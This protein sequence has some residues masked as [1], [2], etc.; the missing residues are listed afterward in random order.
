MNLK[1]LFI[2]TVALMCVSTLLFGTVGCSSNEAKVFKSIT[3]T[4]EQVN[5]ICPMKID[6]QTTLKST[7]AI[8]PRTL[9]YNMII[10][11]P[12]NIE[13]ETISAALK[14]AVMQQIKSNAGVKVLR[15]MDVTFYYSYKTSNGKTIADIEVTPEDYK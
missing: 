3:E 4:A 10:K 2:T 5:K 1:K 6:A 14:P 13:V 15:D 12:Q 9:K 7:E 11:L 8:E